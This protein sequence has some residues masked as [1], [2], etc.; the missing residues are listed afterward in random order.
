MKVW[1]DSAT[2]EGN[3]KTHGAGKP[4]NALPGRRAGLFV[5]FRLG[6]KMVGT[7]FIRFGLVEF[8]QRLFDAASLTSFFGD[9]IG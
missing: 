4:A 3:K 2:R 7:I 8:R 6:I 9:V 1:C 5:C